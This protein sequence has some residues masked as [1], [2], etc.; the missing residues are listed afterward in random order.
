M[1]VYLVL[2]P[3]YLR[4]SDYVVKYPKKR[5]ISEY[6]KTPGAVAVWPLRPALFSFGAKR[7][8]THTLTEQARQQGNH[9]QAQENDPSSGHQLLDSLA[10]GGR[11]ISPVSFHKVDNAPHADTGTDGSHD[12]S[13]WFWATKRNRALIHARFLPCLYSA[14]PPTAP[15]LGGAGGNI[16]PGPFFPTAFFG[17]KAVPR[18]GR[19]A[20][21]QAPPRG[22]TP[23]NGGRPQVAPTA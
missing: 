4:C 21:A 15:V 17:K 2:C 8:C 3:C 13:E 10:F 19:P 18:P 12:S 7:L 14:P 16:P 22:G 6:M 5:Y 9:L 11:I 20:A 1:V 23:A